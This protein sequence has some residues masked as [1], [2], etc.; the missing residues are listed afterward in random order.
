[1]ALNASNGASGNDLMIA[2][3]NGTPLPGTVNGYF[4]S[5]SSVFNM[6]EVHGGASSNTIQIR[7]TGL[8]DGGAGNDLI[9]S[10]GGGFSN[11]DAGG[12]FLFG[13]A[14]D[15]RITGSGRSDL[16]LG[17]SGNDNLAG[18][19]DDDTYYFSA[20]DT[21]TDI[22][23]EATWYLWDVVGTPLYNAD[24]GSLSEDTVEFSEGISL[25]GLSL[26]WGAYTSKY[27]TIPTLLKTYDTLDISWGAGKAARVMMPDRL[28][29]DVRKN[30]IAQ[31]GRSWGIEHFKFADGTTL[32]MQEMV[33]R[34]PAGTQRHCGR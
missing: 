34:M 27:W 17:G 12:N 32:S 24:S 25:D 4:F 29:A 8:V 5:S 9:D 18:W 16:I 28:D 20:A 11:S 6:L 7:T 2:A 31:A 23:N 3:V 15:D 26:S 13:G 30:L 1:M 14:G 19:S 33:D 22:V 10:V 21:G